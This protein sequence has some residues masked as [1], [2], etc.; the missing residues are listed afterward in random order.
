[1]DCFQP[2]PRQALESVSRRFLQDMD[3][4]QDS[5]KDSISKFMAHVHISVNEMS[6]L[7][8]SNEHRYNYTTPKS[9]LE[10]I[11]LYQ[12]LLLKKDK[13]LKAKMQR[14]ENGLEKL[15]STSAQVVFRSDGLGGIFRVKVEDFAA[16]V[17]PGCAL[18]LGLLLISAILQGP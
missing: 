2:W 7:Y 4:L 17:S 9:F 6:R 8:L 10:Q 11:K 18:A 13:D 15:K 1:M 3:T 14:L 16:W 12:S 5:V